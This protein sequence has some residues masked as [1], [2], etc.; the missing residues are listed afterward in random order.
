MTSDKFKRLIDECYGDTDE[1]SV[2][3]VA[4][5]IWEAGDKRRGIDYENWKAA[6]WVHKHLETLTDESVRATSRYIEAEQTL[7]ELGSSWKFRLASLVFPSL[8]RDVNDALMRAMK[9]D[10][11]NCS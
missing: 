4:E 10:K 6:E 5:K 8:A 7:M 11:E 3:K 9:D 2:R 1:E